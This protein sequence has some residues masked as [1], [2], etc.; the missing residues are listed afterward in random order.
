MSFTTWTNADSENEDPL[1]K[2]IGTYNT[3]RIILI[4]FFK[5]LYYPNVDN[6]KRRNELS[7]LEKKPECIMGIPQL[8]RKEVSCYKPTDLWTQNDNNVIEDEVTMTSAVLLSRFM[9]IT[10]REPKLAFGD[11][12]HKAYRGNHDSLQGYAI[13]MILINWENAKTGVSRD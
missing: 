6:S 4:R 9:L 8:K 5:W 11:G 10:K 7:S 3:K 12:R 2:W 1:H 13:K